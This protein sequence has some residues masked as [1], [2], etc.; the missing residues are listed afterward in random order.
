MRSVYRFVFH[1]SIEKV[2]RVFNTFTCNNTFIR[3]R[4]QTSLIPSRKK[5]NKK[6]RRRDFSRCNASKC[7]I[8][9]LRD[10]VSG[11]ADPSPFD[12]FLVA[13]CS[14]NSMR[15]RKREESKVPESMDD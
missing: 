4:H 1:I 9:M 7:K 12:T 2:R 15:K 8:E 6:K 14:V 11:A 13:E 3:K 10:K 5:E